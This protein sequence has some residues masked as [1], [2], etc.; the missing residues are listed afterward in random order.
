MPKESVIK[1]PDSDVLV[2]AVHYFT[3]MEHVD[4]MWD[5]TGTITSTDDKHLFIPVHVICDALTPD[6]YNIL[7]AVHAFTGCDSVIPV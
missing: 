3:K 4:S 1:S 5:E 2:L 6:F 7:P